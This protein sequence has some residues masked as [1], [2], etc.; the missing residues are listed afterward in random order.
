MKALKLAAMAA[1]TAIGC[2]GVCGSLFT[3]FSMDSAGVLPQGVRNVRVTGF[4]TQISDKH[5]TSGSIVPVGN[6]FNKQVTWNDLIESEPEG[7]ERGKFKGGLEANGIDLDDVAGQAY[8]AVNTRVTSTV[9]IVA[10]GLTEKITVAVG[11]PVIYSNLSISTGWT[12]DDQFNDQLKSLSQ[13]GYGNKV[14]SYQQKLQ[15]V[16]LEQIRAKGYKEPTDEQGTGIGDIT[17]GMKYQVAKGAGYAA[18]IAPKLV[19]PTGRTADVDKLVDVPTGDGQ[20]DIGLS[21]VVDYSPT[22]LVTITPSA[23]YVHQIS[24]RKAKRIP[25]SADS[26]L[27]ADIDYDTTEKLG[28]IMSAGLGM[29]YQADEV[30]S[31]GTQYSYQYKLSDKY[32]GS[33][34]SSERYSYMS[35]ETRQSMHAA[36]VGMTFSTIPWFRKQQFAVPLEATLSLGS[37]LGGVNVKRASLATFDIAAFF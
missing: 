24:S 4:T 10:Y 2:E 9:P 26:S 34:Y 17:L 33:A 27:S 18:A 37:V 5:D 3:P 8:G 19:L 11:V 29:R 31:I 13:K 6:S 36:Q 20:F 22:S 28:D 12:A 15:N 35:D 16:V 23:S 32:S 21:A 7:F 1:I 30:I 14:L 25:T